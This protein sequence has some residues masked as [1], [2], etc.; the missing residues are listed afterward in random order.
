M[1]RQPSPIADT[2]SPSAPN[3]RVSIDPPDERHCLSGEAL[4]PP[5]ET[6]AVGR[7][8]TDRNLVDLRVERPSQPSAH[9]VAMIGDTRALPD[10]DAVGVGQLETSLADHRI[11]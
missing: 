6:E 9:C 7:C 4:F 2:S 3:L 1:L 10:E 8:C 5:D 11:R